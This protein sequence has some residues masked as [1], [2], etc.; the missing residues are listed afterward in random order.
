VGECLQLENIADTNA[1]IGELNRRFPDLQHSKY[2]VAVNKKMINGNTALNVN[3]TVAI[4]SPF[5]GG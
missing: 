3:D 4:M 2:M 1:L 5:S